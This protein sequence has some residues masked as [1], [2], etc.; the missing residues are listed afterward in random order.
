MKCASKK[1]ENKQHIDKYISVSFDIMEHQNV[2]LKSCIQLKQRKEKLNDYS[3][4]RT[5]FEMWQL[6]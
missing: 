3:P 2:L 5:T 6:F 4:K 1:T